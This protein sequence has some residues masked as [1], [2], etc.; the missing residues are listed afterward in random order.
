MSLECQCCEDLKNFPTQLQHLLITATPSVL[1]TLG[2]GIR[3]RSPK[4]R[5]GA[6]DTQEGAAGAEKKDTVT[7]TESQTSV[8]TMV[9][10]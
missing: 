4:A 6:G 10:A 5:T 2:S 9:R 7:A 8:S 3:Q 1:L